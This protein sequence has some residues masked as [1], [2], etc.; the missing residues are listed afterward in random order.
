MIA[1]TGGTPI[2]SG[3]NGLSKALD[4]ERAHYHER[5]SALLARVLRG[6]PKPKPAPGDP[7]PAASPLVVATPESSVRPPLRYSDH[8]PN[9]RA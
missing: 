7:D 1:N 2:G 5:Q 9:L 6:Q 8:G 4:R 3:K